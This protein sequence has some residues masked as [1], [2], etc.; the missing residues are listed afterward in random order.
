MDQ[1]IKARK[2]T[3]AEASKQLVGRI[4]SRDLNAEAEMIARYDAGLRA[5]LYKRSQD[6]CLADDIAQETWL[7]VISKVRK[8]ELRDSAKLAAFIIQI[9][10]NQLLMYYRKRSSSEDQL[11]EDHAEPRDRG[12]TPEQDLQN[13][14]LAALISRLFNG[15]SQ[16]RDRD[17]LQDFYL[18]GREKH[19]LCDEFNITEAHFDRVLSRARQ[20]FK[21]L[22]EQE[23]LAERG[24]TC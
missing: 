17:I 22:W 8:G 1:R 23:Q 20:R 5:L 4:L 24:N 19:E 13:T 21:K 18:V 7:V 11:G 2:P 10:K 16:K 3:E 15:M 9:G 14:Q 12:L 6:R